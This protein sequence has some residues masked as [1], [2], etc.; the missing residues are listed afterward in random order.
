MIANAPAEI[1]GGMAAPLAPL[2]MLGG[3]PVARYS[4]TFLKGK[5]G[6][7]SPDLGQVVQARHEAAVR[8]SANSSSGGDGA[9]RKC[10]D[11]TFMTTT[12]TAV[13]ATFGCI[14]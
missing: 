1:I 9:E 7:R 8:A 3:N 4:V 14:K 6:W 5:N 12:E 2:A 10:M 11:T 13:A